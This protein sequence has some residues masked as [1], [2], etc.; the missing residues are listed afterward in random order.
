MSRCFVIRRSS[1]TAN[2]PYSTR[3][4]QRRQMEQIQEQLA[5][6]RAQL[7]EQINAQMAQFMEALV[8]VTKG[9]DDLR[10]LV[11]NSRR[12]ENGGHSRL[13][14]DAS[15]RID[16]PHDPNEFDRLGGQY[17]PVN[18]NHGFAPPSRLLGRRE[19]QNRDNL[20]FNVENFEQVSTHSA[21]GAHEEVERDRLIEE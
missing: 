16:A 15:G 17:N 19:N 20:D 6:M 18:Q 10:V 3:S 2:H 21:D 11:E 12:V 4:S 7:R 5:E 8:N 13:F 14:A 9:Q 1:K